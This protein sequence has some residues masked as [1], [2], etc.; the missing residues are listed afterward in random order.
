MQ[1]LPLTPE[2]EANVLNDIRNLLL[3]LPSA[4][5]R[6]PI[7]IYE[8]ISLVLNLRQEI[9]ENLNQIIHEYMILRA[10]EWLR[11]H[12]HQ[13]PQNRWYWNPRQTGDKTE[14][15]LAVFK[16]EQQIASAEITTSEKPMGSIDTRMSDTLRK[17]SQMPGQK[18]FFVRTDVMYKRAATKVREASFAIKVV[19]LPLV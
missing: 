7:S 4:S 15:D 14:P 6:A 3:S 1:P 2:A 8:G 10:A 16:D 12:G 19:L 5:Q 11:S 18:F 9:Y 13:E 17:L